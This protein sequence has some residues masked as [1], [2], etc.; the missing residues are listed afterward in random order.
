MGKRSKARAIRLGAEHGIEEVETVL[1]EQGAEVVIGT[2]S[3][4]HLEWDEGAINGGAAEYAGVPRRHERAY[5]LAYSKA[6]RARAE[7]IER[8]ANA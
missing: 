3:P 6:A 4:G 8:E 5:Y 1:R 2:L 7:E